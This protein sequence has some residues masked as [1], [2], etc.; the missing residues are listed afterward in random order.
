MDTALRRVAFILLACFTLLF[1][2][3]NRLQVYQ[4]EDLA[5]HPAN[6]RTVLRDFDRQRADIISSDG[7]L[8]ATSTEAEQGS[9]RWQRE[10]PQGE[11]YAHTVGYLGFTTG[12]DGMERS[13]HDA[14]VGRTSSQQLVDLSNIL[15]P[16]TGPGSI[17]ATLDHGLQ[18]TARRALGNRQGSVVALDPSTGA[19]RAMWSW[20]SFDP[21]LLSDPDSSVSTSTYTELLNAEANPLRSRAYR[22]SLAPGSTFKVITAAAALEAGAVTLTSPVFEATDGYVAPLT[23][24]KIQNFGGRTCGGNLVDL[25]VRSC[26]GPFAQL[27]AE[28]LGPAVMINQAEAA[29]FNSVPPVDLPAPIESSYPVDYGKELQTPNPDNP[30]GLYEN[31]P[32]LAQTAIGQ[33][34][35]RATPLQMAL[36]ISGIA[37]DGIIPTPHVLQAIQ[38]HTGQTI[39]ENSPGPWRQ[40][41]RPETAADL[42]EALIAAATDGGGATAAVNGLVVGA[43]TGTA[44]VGDG[45]A[46]SHAWIVAFAGPPDG[47]PQLAVAVLVEAT[48]GSGDQTGG[49]VAGPI[50]RALFEEFF[51]E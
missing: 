41:M 30:A 20:P 14:L 3:L 6:T 29:G 23:S 18:D 34:E 27:A 7:V 43:K 15:N 19:I 31:T 35:V 22:E 28:E 51:T 26:N 24:H 21:N 49:R 33:N 39:A 42:R 11:L 17:V 32:V 9:F 50:A 4:A 10:Y 44:E 48:E 36:L 37:N 8:L 47:P 25:L 45:S 46:S 5:N 12:A 40:A 13:H 38:T 1:A 16:D 2:Q